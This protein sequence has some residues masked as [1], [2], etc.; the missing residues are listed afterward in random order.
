M[1]ERLGGDGGYLDKIPFL[2]GIKRQFDGDIGEMGLQQTFAKW[3]AVAGKDKLSIRGKDK[4]VKEILREE[5]VVVVGN[6]P[7]FAEIA[8]V[9]ASLEPRDDIYGVGISLFLG[10]G[11]NISRHVFPVYKTRQMSSE[12]Q[13][14]L[15][16]AGYML[17]LGPRISP[18]EAHK[19]NV[20]SINQA[21]DAVRNGCLVIIFPEGIRSGKDS[22]WSNG[23]GHLLSGIGR[24]LN[25]YL[26]FVYSDGVSNWDYL[27]VVPYV[28]K[29]I[30]PASVTFA[31]PKTID[32]FL[33][34]GGDPRSITERLKTDYYTWVRSLY[35]K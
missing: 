3:V 4:R 34:K 7:S 20:E 33:E 24:D 25:G 16:R 14:L 30:P 11:P 2:S 13:K 17:H 18:D 28:K 31:E 22:R 1:K 26:I 23:V 5:P 8:T 27:R 10:I 9:I 12:Q 35:R 15:V 6:H 29:L 19:R 32:S 21:V